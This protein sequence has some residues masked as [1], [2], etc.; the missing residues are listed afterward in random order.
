[1]HIPDEA[2]K[3]VS[4]WLDFAYA[5]FRLQRGEKEP[6]KLAAVRAM[7]LAELAGPPKEPTV[8][9]VIDVKEAGR[10]LHCAPRTV[11]SIALELGGTRKTGMWVFSRAK[12]EEYARTPRPRKSP[13]LPRSA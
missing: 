8:G 6:P 9:D 4:K 2:V 12:V 5:N 3:E 13:K 1:M 10:I 7:F 11:R